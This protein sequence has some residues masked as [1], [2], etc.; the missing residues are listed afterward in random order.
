MTDSLDQAIDLSRFSPSDQKRI[1]QQH[2]FAVFAGNAETAGKYELIDENADSRED[3]LKI[4]NEKNTK[5]DEI[6]QKYFQ[7]IKE[8]AKKLQKRLN[9]QNGS[10]KDMENSVFF[11]QIIDGPA[12]GDSIIKSS[13]KRFK[14]ENTSIIEQ[15]WAYDN[16]NGLLS[17]TTPNEKG[18]CSFEINMAGDLSTIINKFYHEI[19]PRLTNSEEFT[20]SIYFL[21]GH[22]ALAS[23]LEEVSGSWLEHLRKTPTNA[24]HLSFFD[25][26]YYGAA[27]S[28]SKHIM[29]FAPW[30]SQAKNSDVDVIKQGSEGDGQGSE[31]DGQGSE[32]DGQGSEDDGQGSEGDGQGAKKS[33]FWSLKSSTEIKEIIAKNLKEQ[34]LNTNIVFKLGDALSMDR[35][36]VGHQLNLPSGT[37][38]NTLVLVDSCYGSK[39]IRESVI[40]KNNLE[41]VSLINPNPTGKTLVQYDKLDAAQWSSLPM[42]LLGNLNKD[43]FAIDQS[44]ATFTTNNNYNLRYIENAV[45]SALRHGNT[46]ESPANPESSCFAAVVSGQYYGNNCFENSENYAVQNN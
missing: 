19:G 42:I 1:C 18:S 24:D 33:I 17:C 2:L 25:T 27:N 46:K 44:P 31:G 35:G 26:N 3:D 6:S 38:E 21:K 9:T 15:S 30:L 23:K 43:N 12:M 13:Y 39:G 20:Q 41:P 36:R 7:L 16:S 14:T 8:N 22:G 32:G 45:L 4:I 37:R 11:V 34:N 28:E 5:N 10:C 40:S 29:A